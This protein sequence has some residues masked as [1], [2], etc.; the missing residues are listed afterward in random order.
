MTQHSRFL[1]LFL[2]AVMFVGCSTEKTASEYMA[3]AQ[4]HQ[5]AGEIRA[6]LIQ[7]R[8]AVAQDPESP[9]ARSLLG[10]L[11]L[12]AS[13]PV[14]AE[15]A[16]LRAV[17]LGISRD[18]VI[19]DLAQAYLLQGKTDEL[20]D[21]D[22]STLSDKDRADV[23]AFQTEAALMT[24]EP[25]M[26][27]RLGAESLLADPVSA[28]A[29]TANARLKAAENNIPEAR[30]Y[31]AIATDNSPGYSPAWE[32]SGDIDANEQRFPEAINM[33]SQAVATAANQLSPLIKRAR[34]HLALSD[35]EAAS[36]DTKVLESA[37][38]NSPVI[39][40]IRAEI[41]LRKGDFA[42][43]QIS[44]E[45]ALKD[46]PTY[47][48]AVRTIAIT[49]MLQGNIGQAE[50]FGLQYAD[51]E[52][53][54]DARIFLATIR[55]QAM[56]FEQAEKTLQPLTDSGRLNPLGAQVLATTLLK[57][58]KLDDAINTMLGLKNDLERAGI[59]G[60]VDLAM[61]SA[62]ATVMANQLL[63]SKQ[64]FV[65]DDSGAPYLTEPDLKLINAVKA[66]ASGNT[67]SAL[68]IANSLLEA[69]HNN[70]AMHG[71]IGRIY[72]SAGETTKAAE[73]LATSIEL[74]ETP[75]TET[76]MAA[77]IEVNAG[78]PAKA[79]KLLNSALN[80]TRGQMRERVLMALATISAVQKDQATMLDWL[81]QAYT[82]NPSSYT[83]SL[84]LANYHSRSGD[85]ESVLD[86]LSQ[87]S[88]MSKNNP[89]VI[90]LK[91][92]THIAL[93][94]FDKAV[95]LVSPMVQ[96]EPNTARW[97]FLRAKANAGKNDIAAV[98]RD[99]D[100]AL[101][102]DP[103][104]A[105][106]LMAKTNLDLLK[107]DFS[108]AESQLASLKEIM[109][110]SELVDQLEERI[111]SSQQQTAQSTNAQKLDKAPTTT[112]EVM[113]AARSQW[114]SG[115]KDAALGTLE[116]WLKDFP[117][118]ITVGLTLANSYSAAD[119]PDDAIT[120]FRHVLNRDP[121]NF[122]ALN[123]LA[124]HLRNDDPDAALKHAEHA[125]SLQ[126]DNVATLDTLAVIQLEQNKLEAAG[127]TFSKIR[128]LNPEDP[129]ILYHGAMIQS[130]I[131]NTQDA[132]SI[133]KPLIS[134]SIDFP[135]VEA[136]RN[137]YDKL[138]NEQ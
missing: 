106:S 108:N 101:R 7:T 88:D 137:L 125:V 38:I 82:E 55:L 105:P 46:F 43:A 87:Q 111:N 19:R 138:Q 86:A 33:Y 79:N 80:Q 136:A 120:A 127:E 52:K 102:I 54:D 22:A 40:L 48:P 134:N 112:E 28:P 3:S 116:K 129:M 97:R 6:A 47:S 39:K 81:T 23:L 110:D 115:Q 107:Q 90:E 66:L 99:L 42:D 31:L 75:G 2:T 91:A 29:L 85:H 71:L 58:N 36:D 121:D 119:R 128:A 96:L 11:E 45:Q 12:M 27:A 68:V 73:S 61:L 21:I 20:L 30:T 118:D 109:P 35:L 70:A 131:G 76:I 92:N 123:N 104:H 9:E 83:A 18:S 103:K 124:W 51:S 89:A 69:D 15:S 41:Q 25:A 62:P 65:S 57:Q 126:P 77:M 8:N 1:L 5:Q 133:L 78:D 74:A 37:K 32:L 84:A 53:T 94:D 10:E 13:N 56:R 132:L 50:Q 113:N 64:K 135:E 72:V 24:G 59:T 60:P 44:L 16:L 4:A 14:D 49:H 100:N 98:S 63:G 26:A 122:I 95:E 114:G 34:I 17:D 67:D 93:G 117:D 130:A